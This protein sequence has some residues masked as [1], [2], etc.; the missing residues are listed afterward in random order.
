M[1]FTQKSVLLA[2]VALLAFVANQESGFMVSAQ[3]GEG[4]DKEDKEDDKEDED[5]E[6]PG[7]GVETP[8]GDMEMPDGVV[9]PKDEM[10]MDDPVEINIPGPP[11]MS[12]ITDELDLPSASDDSNTTSLDE[13]CVC[14]ADSMI[15]CSDPADE[16]SCM[17]DEMGD[18]VC[19]DY[20]PPVESPTVG[21]MAPDSA[22]W[23]DPDEPPA[24][25]TGVSGAASAGTLV[26]VAL[27]AAG[28]AIA[29]N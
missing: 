19:G 3:V 11:P 24:P 21:P 22:P 26:S 5:M 10:P 18:V 4:E 1:L 9:M 14:D 27:S 17:C 2:T 28:L 20:D 13:G 8:P 29:L 7:G 23:S 15:S 6:M 12:N 16:D 25:D